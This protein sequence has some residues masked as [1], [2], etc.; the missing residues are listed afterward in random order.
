MLVEPLE[1]SWKDVL[2]RVLRPLGHAVDD[3]AR[4][5]PRIAEL[6]RAY[7]EGTAEG[8]KTKLPLEARIAFSFPRDVPKGSAAV[9]E[10]VAGLAS[11]RPLRI[12]DLGAGLGAMTWGIARAL[13]AAGHTGA[14]EALLIDEDAEALKAAA[15]IAREAHASG[16]VLGGGAPLSITT[17]V[18]GVAQFAEARA[19]IAVL[20]QVLSELNPHGN[21]GA[22][23]AEH[24]SLVQRLLQQAA[25]VV[26]VEPALRDRT[27]HLHALRDRLVDA[28]AFVHAPCLH[29]AH[30]P[31]LASPDDWCHEDLTAVDLPPWVAPLAKAAGLRWQG[32]TF[33][34][35]VL[36]CE[37]PERPA[38]AGIHFRV[39]SDLL[40]SKG[41]TELF[42]CRADGQRQRIRRLERE[43]EELDALN[44]GDIVTIST[45]DGTPPIDERGRVA[46]HVTIDVRSPRH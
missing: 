36:R 16:A 28:G 7:N 22:R 40:K 24:V 6:S 1:A 42:A 8:K 25:T 32:L 37:A 38:R 41:K 10:V 43:G 30:C 45:L 20:G 4:L 2:D 12:L 18:G 11:D 9:R 21:A 31:A 3:V 14:I 29:S 17:R 35:V 34:Y 46:K 15:A 27:R 39:T 13:G 5:G 26:I 44:R 19:D 23:L 33:S